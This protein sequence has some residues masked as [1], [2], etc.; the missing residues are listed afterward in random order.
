MAK[1]KELTVAYPVKKRGATGSHISTPKSLSLQL[2]QHLKDD[3][4]FE[5]IMYELYVLLK[6]ESWFGRNRKRGSRFSR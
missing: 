3:A 2:L 1:V 4:T 5:D 6:D